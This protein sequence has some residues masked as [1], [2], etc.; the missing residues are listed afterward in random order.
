[1]QV[2]ILQIHLIVKYVMVKN[3]MNGCSLAQKMYL[4]SNYC[5]KAVL[6]ATKY[7][8]NCV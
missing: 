6:S 8:L 4:T 1:M 7:G 5:N 3:N 2:G